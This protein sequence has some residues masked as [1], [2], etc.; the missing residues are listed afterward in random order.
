MVSTAAAELHDRLLDA[1]APQSEVRA[2]ARRLAELV[3]WPIRHAT[4]GKARS[5]SCRTT[6]CT[7]FR[8]TSCPGRTR[9]PTAWSCNT[10]RFRLPLPRC[11]SPVSVPTIHNTAARR[12][13]NCWAI[14]YSESPTGS[15]S[16]VSDAAR[17]D[18]RPSLTR[19]IDWTEALPR[20]PGSRAEVQMVARLSRESRPASRI[21]TLLGCAAVPS[22]PAPG[23]QRA[24]GSA[25]HRDSRTRGFATTAA[26]CPGPD[27]RASRME[28]RRR[29]ACSTFS[30]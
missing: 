29:S 4:S 11:F 7:R 14:P 26:V 20:L 6:D 25:A 28:R 12:G 10:R 23:R 21:E 1:E 18:E 5:S 9:T 30:G 17:T 13:S 22:S 16:A 24:P 19:R 3:L 8:S 2:A 27:P 15:V